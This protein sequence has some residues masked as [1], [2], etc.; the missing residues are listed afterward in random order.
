MRPPLMSSSSPRSGSTLALDVRGP[1]TLDRVLRW[2]PVRWLLGNSSLTLFDQ[3]IFSGTNFLITV[4]LGRFAGAESLGVY[5][6]I[7][8]VTIMVLSIHES[9][10]CLPYAIELHKIPRRAATAYAGSTL[11]QSAVLAAVAA[12]L[13][14]GAGLVA[15][16]TP[17]AGTALGT[18][19]CIFAFAAPSMILRDFGR[20]YSLA[21][22]RPHITVLIDVGVSVAVLSGL[23]GLA[24]IG[25]LSAWT[26]L[27]V[28]GVGAGAVAAVWLAAAR[29]QFEFRRRRYRRDLRRNWKLGRWV[30][31]SQVCSVITVYT[32]HW[33]IAALLGTT[34]TGIFVAAAAMVLLTNPFILG[35]QN[36]L[37]PTISHEIAERGHAS[38]GKVVFDSTLFLLVLM[39]LFLVVVAL[40]G[41][42]FTATVYGAEFA[43]HNLTTFVYAL[44]VLASSIG[45][46]TDRALWA[47]HHPH[48]S[49]AT[50]L[51]GLVVTIAVVSV[52]LPVWG[53]V[54]GPFGLMVGNFTTT[55]L[56]WGALFQLGITRETVHD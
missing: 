8:G 34:D 43:G 37:S 16:L 39:L 53:I 49:F 56:R 23:A 26:A 3:V 1:A 9:L 42:R 5:A 54:G 32:P 18:A 45:M 13:L 30:F 35:V 6:L 33:L 47:T 51:V 28:L 55:A 52:T 38:I 36:L 15:W 40:V 12:P 44:S 20:R 24:A 11:V 25:W 21:H 48:V 22:L 17:I 50:G 2:K 29:R 14:L 31:S 41:E 46:P 4:M 10:V 7:F 27:A 19:L